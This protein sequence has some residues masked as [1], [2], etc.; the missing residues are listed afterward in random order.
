[1]HCKA[2]VENAIQSL[3]GVQCALAD[4]EAKNVK[5]DYDESRVKDA[6]L[7]AAVEG[8]GHYELQI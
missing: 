4:I 3:D 1:M 6:D 5:V 8:A 7:K 2:N